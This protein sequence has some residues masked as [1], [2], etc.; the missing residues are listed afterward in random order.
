[1]IPKECGPLFQGDISNSGFAP[2]PTKEDLRALDMTSLRSTLGMCRECL[3]VAQ[4]REYA[5][6]PHL[7]GTIAW[8][9]LFQVKIESAISWLRSSLREANLAN[10]AIRKMRD[11]DAF[12]VCAKTLLPRSV[13][14]EIWKE[15]GREQDNG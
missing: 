15:A 1:M 14:L 7:V 5:S 11:N 2:H 3:M 6:H 10:D 4:T 8:Y 12:V 9:R 13:Y